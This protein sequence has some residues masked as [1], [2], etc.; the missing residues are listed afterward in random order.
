MTT[1]GIFYNKA[2]KPETERIAKKIAKWLREIG[3]KIYLNPSKALFPNINFG[4][5]VGGD[6]TVLGIADKIAAYDIPIVGI[7]FGHEG[8]LCAIGRNEI[9]KKIKK[10]LQMDLEDEKSIRYR[11]RIQA[12]VFNDGKVIRQV[13]GLNEIV[14]GGIPKTVFLKVLITDE[15]DRC[16]INILGDG[17]IAATETGSSA[18][19]KNAGGQPFGEDLFGILANNASVENL[20]TKAD[21]SSECK[22]FPE[23]NKLVTSINTKYEIEVTQQYK[24]NLPYL[25]ADGQRIYRLK[26]GDSVV[27]TKSANVNKFIRVPE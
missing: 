18:Y 14:I 20:E 5:V 7:N 9:R 17:I 12:E 11:T 13:E 23:K 3:H 27:I 22:A 21:I 15:K 4:I 16:H 26:P 24:D 1:V 10:I 6:G 25:T 19:W 2:R 8:W